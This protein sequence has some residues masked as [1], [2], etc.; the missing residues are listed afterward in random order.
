MAEPAPH[1]IVQVALPVPIRRTFDY[2]PKPDMATNLLT[3]GT[4]VKVP[5]GKRQMIGIIVALHRHSDFGDDKLKPISALLDDEPAV[6]APLF[7]LCQWAADYYHHPIGEVLSHAIPTLL[8]NK[9]ESWETT[10]VRWQ[11]T[12]KG[13]LL[14]LDQLGRAKRQIQ[15]IAILRDHE[16]GLHLPMLKSLEVQTS[17]L[18]A[19]EKKGLVQQHLEIPPSQHWKRDKILAESPLTLNEEQKHALAPVLDCQQFRSFLLEGVTGSGK[20]EVYLQAI[21]H[22]LKQGKQALVLVP[23]IGLTPQTLHR[24]Q[25]RFAVP[26]VSFHSNLTDKERLISWRK[27]RK[28]EAAVLLGTRSA[29]FAPTEN[30]GMIIVDEEHDLS[31]KQQEGFRY[32]ARDLAVIRARQENIPVLLGSATPTL[33]SLNNARSGRYE[34]LTLNQRAG[35]ANPPQFRVLD[36]R[37][38]ALTHGLAPELIGE[39]EA[40]LKAKQQ[41]LVFINRRGYAPVLMCHDCGWFKECPHCDHRMTCHANP[42]HLHC[43]HCNHQ[44]AIPKYCG[45]CKSTDLRPIGMGTERLEDNLKSLFPKFPVI[46]IDRDTTQ[47][48]QAMSQHLEKINSGQPCILVGTQMLAKG[49]HFPKVTLVAVCDIDAGLFAADFRATEHTAQLLMQVAGRAGRGT[50]Q[51]LVFLQTHQ[52]GHPLL[53]TLLQAG[54]GAFATELS[55]ERRLMGMPPYGYLALLRAESVEPSQA[56]QFLNQTEMWLRNLAQELRV[57]V[58]GPAPALMPKRARRYRFQLMFR[59]EQRGPLQQ[60][61]AVVS[62]HLEEHTSHRLKW[63]IDVDPVTLD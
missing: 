35:D 60:L 57:D 31:Y 54:Y 26:V 62:K 24:F 38:K 1:T 30:L 63:S 12:Q 55:E 34:H 39:M 56:S 20:T 15:A 36:I 49:H 48:K 33:E 45:K 44:S 40:R 27:I 9:D 14:G 2:V 52:P 7:K 29:L 6:T 8:R 10:S 50:L 41:V 42:A 18:N 37:Q 17:T 19:L 51:G 32:N 47:R 3:P 5:F 46:R 43:H 61:L 28:G 11:L 23:E 25:H 22:C 21:E 58:W 59:A 53:Q 13:R 4:R 16:A